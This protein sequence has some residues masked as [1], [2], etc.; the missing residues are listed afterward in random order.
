MTGWLQAGD[1]FPQVLFGKWNRN[2]YVVA[3]AWRWCMK[4][5]PHSAGPCM[6]LSP[7]QCTKGPAPDF[8]RLPCLVLLFWFANYGCL[9][10]R[11]NQLI[12]GTFMRIGL[13]VVLLF[14]LVSVCGARDSEQSSSSQTATNSFNSDWFNASGIVR[15]DLG[16]VAS[17]DRADRDPSLP[18]SV[19]DG[20]L[21]CFTMHTFLVKRVGP[22]SD[23][24]EPAG[25]STCLAGSRY[26]V[27]KVEEPGKAPPR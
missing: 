16:S 25:Q 17:S 19:R 15:P 21:T 5:A 1:S 27:R 20:D 11:Y 18:S 22:H 23:V 8:L 6:R 13:L 3:K 12:G 10:W 9:G 7:I 2:H 4:V 14:A 24:T 26:N